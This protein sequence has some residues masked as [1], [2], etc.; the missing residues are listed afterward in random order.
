M[1]GG[2]QTPGRNTEGNRTK[3]ELYDIAEQEAINEIDSTSAFSE[4]EKQGYI[5]SIQAARKE[6]ET[7]ESLED[8]VK[9]LD[10]RDLAART[11]LSQKA[12]DDV[13][14]PTLEQLKKAPAKVAEAAEESAF[15]YARLVDNF[16]KIYNLPIENIV[17]SIQNGGEKERITSK[18]HLCRRKAGRRY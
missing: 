12:Y 6:V 18:R 15:V 1:T 11:L 5:N 3:R 14:V 13:Y 2:M 8:Y 17:A 16:S 10:T 4:E 9:E 7:I